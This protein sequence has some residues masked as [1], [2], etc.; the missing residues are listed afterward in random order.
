[1]WVLRGLCYKEG[2]VWVLEFW[3]EDMRNWNT[4]F[5]EGRK[6]RAAGINEIK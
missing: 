2:L 3:A 1:M 5:G 6:V 4:I